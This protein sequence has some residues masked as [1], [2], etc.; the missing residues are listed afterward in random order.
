MKQQGFR[1]A[2]QAMGM[3]LSGK[4]YDDGFAT[5]SKRLADVDNARAT[6]QYRLSQIGKNDSD[7]ALNNAKAKELTTSQDFRDNPLNYG[8]SVAAASG[9]PTDTS[10]QF[11]SSLTGMGGPKVEPAMDPEQKK[12]AGNLLSNLLLGKMVSKPI[13]LDDVAKA[14]DTQSRLGMAQQSIETAKTDPLKAIF[15]LSVGNDQKSSPD[16]FKGNGAGSV[17]NTLTGSQLFNPAAVEA[18]TKPI[19]DSARGVMIDSGKAVPVV[20]ANGLPIGPKVDEEAKQ[21]RITAQQ[22]KIATAKENTLT[23]RVNKFSGE[24][25]KTGIAAFESGLSTAEAKIAELLAKNKDL[26]GYGPLYSLRPDFLTNKDG[27]ELRQ[28]IQ[29]LA[30]TVLKERSGAAVTS[31]ELTRVMKELGQGKLTTE[32]QLMDGLANLRRAFDEQKR[33]TV[34]G[35]DDDTLNRYFENGGMKFERGAQPPKSGS[36]TPSGTPGKSLRPKQGEIRDGYRWKG[37]DTG[38]P[39]DPKNWEKAGST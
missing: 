4:A 11:I 12:I 23:Q 14:N 33:N 31:Q 21:A 37:G 30:N 39:N 17:F 19:Y 3:A 10:L 32:K 25:E 27:V 38:N 1:N 7:V 26:P 5:E 29:T 16:L 9:L 2:G 24:I 6:A 20:G 15:Q 35:V 13:G 8:P 22:D 28:L 18:R 36:A 34:A